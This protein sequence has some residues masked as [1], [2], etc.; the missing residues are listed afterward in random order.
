[1]ISLEL[2]LTVYILAQ[3]LLCVFSSQ[4]ILVYPCT[5]LLC[6]HPNHSYFGCRIWTQQLLLSDL[7]FVYV[8][9][10]KV[11]LHNF[12]VLSFRL[13]ALWPSD[14]EIYYQMIN[15]FC[16]KKI[17]AP[18]YYHSGHMHA[19]QPSDL[20]IEFIYY[21]MQCFVLWI[22]SLHRFNCIIIT[23]HACVSAIR[24]VCRI[25]LLSYLLFQY[26]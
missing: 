16:Y 23:S 1:M 17:L 9:N 5:I 22:R 19:S 8:D 26:V 11:S 6:D 2:T 13:H 20:D 14:M 7:L 4:P 3:I 24:F 18:I 25:L 15:C 10:I 21:M 12:I